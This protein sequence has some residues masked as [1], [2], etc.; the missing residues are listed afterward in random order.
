M[1]EC[2]IISKDGT[3][4]IKRIG[5]ELCM[6]TIFRNRICYI[7]ISD[8]FLMFCVGANYPSSIF[9]I[10]EK[11]YIRLCMYKIFL[12][13]D[14]YQLEIIYRKSSK[15]V[16]MQMLFD[17]IMQSFSFGNLR[18]WIQN[19]NDNF[20][21]INLTLANCQ[22]ENEVRNKIPGLVNYLKTH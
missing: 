12:Q 8:Q 18:Y 16:Y 3:K 14:F 1:T 11:E 19:I 13:D 17:Y 22:T 5:V 6:P 10:S 9:G 21:F 4:I 20:K 15:P 7:S 2:A